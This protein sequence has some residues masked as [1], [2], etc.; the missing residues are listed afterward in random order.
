MMGTTTT[1][2]QQGTGQQQDTSQQGTGQQQGTGGQ[3][4]AIDQLRAEQERQ[5]GVLDRIIGILEGDTRQAVGQAHDADRQVVD[6]RL[7]R[8]SRI[9]D[10]VRQAVRDVQAEQAAAQAE[11]L[12]QADHARLREQQQKPAETA[13]REVIVSGKARLQRIMFGADK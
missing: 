12:H 7:D 1:G 8:G 3:T 4:G 6:R 9:A 2:Q 13:P 10:D 5:A 11:Q